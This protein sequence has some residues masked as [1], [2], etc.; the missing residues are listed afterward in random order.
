MTI[1]VRFS[2]RETDRNA[3]WKVKVRDPVSRDRQKV[4]HT[5]A[6]RHSHTLTHYACMSAHMRTH[7]HTISVH[8]HIHTHTYIQTFACTLAHAHTRAHTPT[9]TVPPAT[10]IVMF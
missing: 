8:V 2:H 10:H 6:C 9:Q 4:T 3:L 7:I 5:H 1:A